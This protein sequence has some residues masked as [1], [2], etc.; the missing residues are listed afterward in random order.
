[1]EK[2]EKK[3]KKIREKRIER[4][5]ELYPTHTHTHFTYM[6]IYIYIH[7]PAIRAKHSRAISL[8]HVNKPVQAHS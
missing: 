3:K 7:S 1:M 4:K 8:R 2:K 6:Y 5:N